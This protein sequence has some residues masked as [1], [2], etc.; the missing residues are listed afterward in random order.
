MAKPMYYDEYFKANE[1]TYDRGKYNIVRTPCGSGKTFHCLNVITANYDGEYGRRFGTCDC[2]RCLY[3]TDTSA[4]K[5]NVINSYL[6]QTGRKKVNMRNLEVLTYAKLGREIEL[7]GIKTIAQTYDYIFLDEIHQLFVYEEH[8]D[9]NDGGYYGLVIDSLDELVRLDTTLICLSA[10]PNKLLDYIRDE[11]GK[12]EF[13]RVKDIVPISELHKIKSYVNRY[14]IPVFDVS[15]AISE[16]NLEEDDKLFIYSQTIRDLQELERQCIARGWTTC[17]LWSINQNIKYDG[18]KRQLARK[19]LT[20][21][22]RLYYEE[23]LAKCKPMDDYQLAVREQVLTIGEFPTQVIL[24]NASYESGINLE[25]GQDSKQRTIHVVVNSREEH[26]QQQARGRI[27]HDIDCFWFSGSNAY[28]CSINSSGVD[29]N[30]NLVKRLEQLADECEQDE[31]T[32]T[33]NDGRN[34]ISSI[35]QLYQLYER[36]NGSIQ[37]TK[38]KSV[39]AMNTQLM[40]LELPFKIE[41]TT[42]RKKV[43]GKTKAITYYVVIR[44]GN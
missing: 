36:K 28:E 35:L 23:E 44:T 10:T 21:N 41:Q 30:S 42:I 22:E 32:F 17:C 38:C 29:C 12:G 34:K 33:G 18:I 6:K 40:L 2:Y 9:E 20:E 43:N 27:R 8:F 37:R 31:F 25:N 11:I 14:E 15:Q 19:N 24:M 1:I 4:L 39:D 5:E 7:Q 3:V 16:I 13:N 26:V